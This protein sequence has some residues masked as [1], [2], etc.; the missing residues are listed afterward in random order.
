MLN[1]FVMCGD[2]APFLN[3]FSVTLKNMGM[4][5]VNSFC[6]LHSFFACCFHPIL[7]VENRSEINCQLLLLLLL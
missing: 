4:F 3:L 2:D 7:E 6:D 5:K 1:V